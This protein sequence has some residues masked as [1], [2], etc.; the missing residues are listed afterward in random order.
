LAG[1][2]SALSA[3]SAIS[4]CNG[5]LAGPPVDPFAAGYTGKWFTELEAY[6]DAGVTPVADAGTLQQLNDTSGSGNHLI[7]T[8]AGA[9]PVYHANSLNTYPV[10]G[11]PVLE[12]D[13]IDD[14][15]RVAVGQCDD[16]PC[17]LVF[18]GWFALEPDY[19]AP[20]IAGFGNNRSIHYEGDA[21]GFDSP[22]TFA[23]YET[24]DGTSPVGGYSYSPQVIVVRI[25]TGVAH[26]MR[27]NGAETFTFTAL[28]NPPGT[29]RLAFGA[30]G[31]DAPAAETFSNCYFTGALY[32]PFIL[33][34]VEAA[35]TEFALMA[36]YAIPEPTV[37]I[38]PTG[39]AS[40]G[41][42]GDGAWE[43][44]WT[45]P[46]LATDTGY[47][48]LIRYKIYV[49]EEGGGWVFHMDRFR[50][51]VGAQL[52]G[53]TFG[54]SYQCRITAENAVGESAPSD[55]IDFVVLM[56]SY[57]EFTNSEEWVAVRSGTALI[58][59]LG[60]GGIGGAG[61]ATSGG[62]GGGGGAYAASMVSIVEG[63]TY[64]ITVPAATE[65]GVT[66]V[67]YTPDS[68]YVAAA[69]GH[70]GGNG[71]GGAGGAGGH[72]A[73]S[74]GDSG[75]YD[76]ADGETAIGVNGANGSGPGTNLGAGTPGIGGLGSTDA[77]SLGNA[78]YSVG[79]GYGGGGGFGT[80]GFTGGG[81]Y[82]PAR[83]T[84]TFL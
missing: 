69:F 35:Q 63:E 49:N 31:S 29:D 71:T 52:S 73:D 39:L 6:S 37:P 24:G 60:T 22:D 76:G 59:C 21:L 64:S 45:A 55:V 18:V 57:F 9:R 81:D 17:T 10:N 78:G 7:Q 72:A 8:S 36:K 61:G 74:T 51:A 48:P 62:H 26:A 67:E 2:L 44:S 38:A 68:I 80:P 19:M 43:I 42:A 28:N 12:F 83:V 70:N 47:L 50:A 40:V 23:F 33:S 66:S 3:L 54:A 16:D 65:S 77:G 56:P 41:T 46:N 79:Y 5:S 75:V 27:V 53:L 30:D 34:D 58:E 82:G 14:F 13:G 4:F 15:I 11:Y 32:Y 1:P 25:E 20:R 84:I